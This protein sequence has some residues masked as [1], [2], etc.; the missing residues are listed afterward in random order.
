M[1]RVSEV[2]DK[3]FVQDDELFWEISRHPLDD[4]SLRELVEWWN[5]AP[6]DVRALR[7]RL[8][9]CLRERSDTAAGAIMAGAVMGCAEAVARLE[10]RNGLDLICEEYALGQLG[11]NPRIPADFVIGWDAAI[12]VA[13]GVLTR[14]VTS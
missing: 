2:K 3:I 1:P 14:R 8:N 12:R 7:S 11:S 10:T 13:T 4:A 6:A 5:S 9:A